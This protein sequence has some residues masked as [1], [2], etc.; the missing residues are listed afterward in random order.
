MTVAKK[1][2]LFDL[3][4]HK[5]CENTFFC[6]SVSS[7][8][9]RCAVQIES[10]FISFEK[11]TLVIMLSIVK[12]LLLFKPVYASKI[13]A[14][15]MN[16]SIKDFLS[17]CEEIL[18]GKVHFLCSECYEVKCIVTITKMYCLSKTLRITSSLS[19]NSFLM[20]VPIL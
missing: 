13:T 9:K 19:F 1:N 16:Y 18:N 3:P 7:L 10:F 17:K 15:K 5:I 4:L 2:Q 11:V 20:E 8:R 6:W 12:L 14:Q